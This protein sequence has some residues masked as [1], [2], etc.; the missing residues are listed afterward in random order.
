M[1]VPAILNSSNSTEFLK[2][3]IQKEYGFNTQIVNPHIKMGF[4]PSVW[5]KSD[6]FKILNSDSTSALELKNVNAKIR[7]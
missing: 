6:A 5:V 2:S 7:R 4:L 1:G 3:Y